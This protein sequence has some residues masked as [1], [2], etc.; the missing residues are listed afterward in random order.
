LKNFCCK[1]IKRFCGKPITP[2]KNISIEILVNHYKNNYRCNFNYEIEYIKD[3]SSF[4][5]AIKFISFAFNSSSVR[6]PHQYRIKK[7]ALEHSFAALKKERWRIQKCRNFDA[8][9][10]LVKETTSKIKGLG[11]LYAY[12]TAF[13]LGVFLGIQPDK[14]Y[15]H[16]GTRKGAINL[17]FDSRRTYIEVNELAK[18]KSTPRKLC[19]KAVL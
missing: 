18:N 12:D 14:V 5:L 2:I 9:Y 4:A 15:L 19:R 16:A 11:E 13:R 8:L 10:D 1:R 7:N 6:H 17:G 3:I